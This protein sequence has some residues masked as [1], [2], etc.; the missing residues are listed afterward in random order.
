MKH[1][2]LRQQL[3]RLLRRTR[4]GMDLQ[5]NVRLGSKAFVE[6]GIDP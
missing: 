3:M 4:H 2:G 5:L 1:M 6:R